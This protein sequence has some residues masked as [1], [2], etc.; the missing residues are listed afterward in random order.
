MVCSRRRGRPPPGSVAPGAVAVRGRC[1][2]VRGSRIPVSRRPWSRRVQGGVHSDRKQGQRCP[3]RQHRA[4]PTRS[5][6]HP[7]G[8]FTPSSPPVARFGPSLPSR[9]SPAHAVVTASP[10]ARQ[11][12]ATAALRTPAQ[13]DHATL[14]MMVIIFNCLERVPSQRPDLASGSAPRPAVVVPGL[15]EH[16]C[17][18]P[19]PQSGTGWSDKPTARPFTAETEAHETFQGKPG[20]TGSRQMGNNE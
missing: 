3:K 2:A 12:L 5:R 18:A 4:T 1:R 16:S 8:P 11:A 9:P 14:S 13:R 17:G 7:P 10:T 20:A 19:A 15:G 6:P